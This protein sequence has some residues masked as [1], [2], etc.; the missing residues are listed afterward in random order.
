MGSND[1]QYVEDDVFTDIHVLVCERD[2]NE[3]TPRSRPI[4]LEQYID[5][6]SASLERVKALQD[7]IGGRY[8]KTRIAKIFFI[9]EP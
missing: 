6:D 3:S 1:Q 7:K 4:I 2:E 8:G 9:D 5:G